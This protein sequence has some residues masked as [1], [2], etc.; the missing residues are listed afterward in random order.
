[1]ADIEGG[2]DADVRAR[3]GKARNSF[4]SLEKV[5]SSREMGKSAKLTIFKT[6]V[7]SVLLYE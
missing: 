4:L 1:M 5:W 2:T 3:T 6:N 7:K